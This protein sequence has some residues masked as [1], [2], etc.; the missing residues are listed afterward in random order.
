MQSTLKDQN[1]QLIILNNTIFNELVEK[2][3]LFQC[4]IHYF[5]YVI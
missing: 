5:G 1:G 2:L 3:W 4:E